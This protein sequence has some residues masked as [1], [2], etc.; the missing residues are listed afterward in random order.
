MGGVP[1]GSSGAEPTGSQALRRWA[2]HARLPQAPPNQIPPLLDHFQDSPWSTRTPG[3]DAKNPPGPRVHDATPVRLTL[4]NYAGTSWL[5][6]A[7]AFLVRR[8]P[9][10]VRVWFT[11]TGLFVPNYRRVPGP[12]EPASS[13]VVPTVVHTSGCASLLL[14]FLLYGLDDTQT[15]TP[16]GYRSESR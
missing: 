14:Y 9:H 4:L 6:T 7:A 5:T 8:Q 11:S 2:H 12:K 13:P 3:N 10:L 16:R 15:A 1:A